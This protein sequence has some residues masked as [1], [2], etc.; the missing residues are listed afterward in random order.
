M[1]FAIKTVEEII[2]SELEARWA[3]RRAARDHDVFRA[4][5][6]VFV[7][8]GG[9]VRAEHVARRLPGRSRD[10]VGA[11]L[12][13]LDAEDVLL[14]E[15]ETVVIAYPFSG[16]ANNF[17]VDFGDGRD[18]YACCAVDALDLAPMI[19]I[20][21]TIRSRCHDCSEPLALEVTPEGPRGGD[22]M[23]V[24]LGERA[25]GARVCTTL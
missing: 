3:A 1:T 17:A 25:D 5:L 18:R 14:L 6:R 21:V 12:R 4:V 24:W 11:A 7:E 16:I 10:A 2:S 22:G 19:G 9:P 20:P 13:T 8:D 15:N 23:F